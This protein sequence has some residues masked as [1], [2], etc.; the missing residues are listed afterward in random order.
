MVI[1]NK[2]PSLIAFKELSCGEVFRNKRA[3]ICMKIEEGIGGQN[4]VYLCDGTLDYFD[5]IDAKVEK[6]C[7]KLVVE[8]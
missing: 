7:C 6:V 1:I 5:D 2:S 4:I 8:D 3:N